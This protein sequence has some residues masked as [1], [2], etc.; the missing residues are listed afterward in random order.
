[1]PTFSELKAR[2][3][4]SGTS[5]A[6]ASFTNSRVN[7]LIYNSTGDKVYFDRL[8][9]ALNRSDLTFV[10]IAGWWL[11]P[12]FSLDGPTSS[13]LLADL[14]KAKSAAGVD[15]RV[16]G[17][18]MAPEV[19]N[20][21]RVQSAGAGLFGLDINGDTM[22]FINLLRAE[23]TLRN[24]AV[25]NI[26]AH[27]AG[28]VHTKMSIVG[29][30]TWAEG[31]TG[32]IDLEKVRHMQRL[33]HDVQAQ[34]TGP[35][36]QGLFDLF[37]AMWNEVRSR[38]VSPGLSAVSRTTRA[39]ITLDSHTTSM[40]DLPARTLTSSGGHMHVQSAR[41]LPQMRFYSGSSLGMSIPSNAP[42]SFAPSGAQE[43]KAVWKHAILAARTYIYIEDQ[44]FSSL[45]I[46]G[47]INQA[48]KA[49][50]EL[51]VILVA[52]ADDPTAP[53][54][55]ALTKAFHVGV[56]TVLLNGLSASQAARVGLFL[57]RSA[58]VF[59]NGRLIHTKSTIIDD[60]WALIGSANA[61]RRSLYTDIEHAVAF[62]DEDGAEVAAYRTELWNFH[63]QSPGPLS[64]SAFIAR[65]FAI[66]MQGSGATNPLLFWQAPIFP[67][68][69][70]FRETSLT[71]DD[72]LQLDELLDIDSTQVW[73]EDLVKAVMS[74]SGS[75][76]I[77]GGGGGTSGGG[78]GSDGGGGGG[79][80]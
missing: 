19:L 42:L 34:V 10:Y 22:T 14:L 59:G 53:S 45:E 37:R 49:N 20:N 56:N 27:P 73:G 52:G 63:L 23:A 67:A 68:G 47:W 57:D 11:G 33:W 41:T 26:L 12:D 72:H 31:Y 24:K 80:S 40:P 46:F 38:P 18:V 8:K 77:S 7:H 36:V 17:W 1:M 3:M 6:V 51:K 58:E 66:P 71:S 61:M 43:I 54:P 39:R 48:I 13:N 9:A 75:T 30:T 76:S 32:G 35:A 78:G 65:W 50:N 4:Y 29:G 2:Y 21:P 16:L 15:V 55:Q 62:M 44:A 70:F 5:P 74:M 64:L 28:A 25:L 69:S 79:S 60:Q